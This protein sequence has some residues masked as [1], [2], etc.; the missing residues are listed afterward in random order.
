MQAAL[1][2]AISLGMIP[3]VVKVDVEVVVETEIEMEVVVEVVVVV[4]VE[5]EVEVDHAVVVVL[6]D[7]GHA[8]KL[9]QQITFDGFAKR[10]RMKQ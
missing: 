7:A 10:A 8:K 9:G 3:G 6:Q 1:P 2:S 4:V 5:V